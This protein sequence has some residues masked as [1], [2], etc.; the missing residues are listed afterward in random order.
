[1]LTYYY[2]VGAKSISVFDTFI[3]T[4]KNERTH[5]IHIPCTIVSLIDIE[6]TFDLEHELCMQSIYVTHQLLHRDFYLGLSLQWCLCR[7]SSIRNLVL[8]YHGA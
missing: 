6:N 4:F 1:L 7:I 8:I 5:H 2:T 3:D